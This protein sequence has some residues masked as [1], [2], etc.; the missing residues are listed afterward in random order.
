MSGYYNPKPQYNPYTSA[1][2]ARPQPLP[3]RQPSYD[4][5]NPAQHGA[6]PQYADPQSGYGYAQPQ[7]YPQQPQYAPPEPETNGMPTINTNGMSGTSYSRSSSTYAGYSGGGSSSGGL[8]GWQIWIGIVVVIKVI[9]LII[10]LN[11]K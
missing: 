7:E 2:A 1:P 4:Y 11:M 9:L 6:Q 10:K 8:T 3:P 5:G